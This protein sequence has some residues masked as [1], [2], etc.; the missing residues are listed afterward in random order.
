MG[1]TKN[2]ED[3]ESESVAEGI[4]HSQMVKAIPE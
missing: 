4:E 1:H 3:F 2:I